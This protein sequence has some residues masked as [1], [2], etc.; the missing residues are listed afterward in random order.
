MKII[1]CSHIIK[2]NCN[3]RDIYTHKIKPYNRISRKLVEDMLYVQD[4]V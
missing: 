2:Y 3:K 4:K 1:N